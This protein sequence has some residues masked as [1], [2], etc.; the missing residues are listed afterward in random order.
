MSEE[1]DAL[2]PEQGETQALMPGSFSSTRMHVRGRT[3]S[4]GTRIEAATNTLSRISLSDGGCYMPGVNGPVSLLSLQN[5]S[6]DCTPLRGHRSPL[7]VLHLNQEMLLVEFSRQFI[8]QALHVF[9]RLLPFLVIYGGTFS[10]L[11]CAVCHYRWG[12]LISLL[13][14]TVYMAHLSVTFLIFSVVGL[15]RV[16]FDSSENWRDRTDRRSQKSDI[17]DLCSPVEPDLNLGWFDVMH[18]VMIPT[19]KT[20]MPVLE[21]TIT[22]L[23]KSSFART[24]IGICLAFEEREED[25]HKKAHILQETFKGRFSFMFASFHPPNLPDHLPGKSSNECW[26]F[27]ELR[28]ELEEVHGI[29]PFDPRVVITVIDDD[30]EMHEKYFEALT[31]HFIEASVER[32]YL[33]TWQ[34]PICQYKNYLRQPVVVRISSLFSTLHE[35]SCLA[36]PLDMHVPFSTYSISLVL[37]S[38][39]GGWDPDYLAEDWHMFAKCSLKTEGR[40]RCKPIFLPVLNYTPEE[41]TYFGTL[42]SRWTQANRHALGVSEL[43]YVLSTIYLALLELPSFRRILLFLWRILPLVAKFTQTHFV[44]GM[45]ATW[46]VMAQVVIHLYMWRSWCQVQDLDSAGACQLPSFLMGAAPSGQDLAMDATQEQIARNSLLVF[47]QQRATAI[48]AFAS[49]LSGGLGAVYFHMV[50]DRV[51]DINTASWTIRW[52]P[53]M[54]LSIELEVSICGLVSSFVYGAIPLW[55]ACARVICNV[56]FPHLVAGMVGRTLN[57]DERL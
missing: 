39:V 53:I 24:N 1:T 40:V 37:A 43:V 55:I 23:G 5:S 42:L 8:F 44:N 13:L 14:F 56:R 57:G 50:K 19:Y 16:Y 31:C 35:L 20:P 28:R 9:S 51:E 29:K 17:D 18:I 45:A 7:H 36:N 4:F 54:W 38:A 22:S 15:L 49:I 25:A 12:V 11:V 6:A 3:A 46:N 47:W 27:Q 10:L 34:P 52:L 2:V 30:S 32:R 33:T 26:A 41:D 21:E 48:L